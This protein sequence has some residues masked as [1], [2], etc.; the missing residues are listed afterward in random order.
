MSAVGAIPTSHSTGGTM[1]KDT[2]LAKSIRR[3]KNPYNEGTWT[4][5]NVEEIRESAN[6]GLWVEGGTMRVENS[7][8]E[9]QLK[10]YDLWLSGEGDDDA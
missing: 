10:A 4:K 7:E 9:N 5:D 2:K 1:F 8:A 6:N 3:R